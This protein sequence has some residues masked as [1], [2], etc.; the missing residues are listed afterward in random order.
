MPRNSCGGIQSRRRRLSR[1]GFYHILFAV[2]VFPL[3]IARYILPSVLATN[4]GSDAGSSSKKSEKE[5]GEKSNGGN[6]EIITKDVRQPT[7]R[8]VGGKDALKNRYPYFVSLQEVYNGAHKCGGSLVSKST[9]PR[10][11][12][13]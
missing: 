2:A 5:S 12:F 3:P 11:N 9:F 8:I 1:F 4:I 6:E 13:C 7:K 10:T